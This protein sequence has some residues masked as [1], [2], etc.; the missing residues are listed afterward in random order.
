[1]SALGLIEALNTDV[2]SRR[3]PKPYDRASQ[4]SSSTGDASFFMAICQEDK[5]GGDISSQKVHYIED[6]T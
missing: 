1:M 3:R 4:P 5:V 2:S 6:E